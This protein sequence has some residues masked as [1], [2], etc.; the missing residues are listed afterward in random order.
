MN[1]KLKSL[2]AGMGPSPKFD[3]N[4]FGLK[5]TAAGPDM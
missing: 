1:A 4:Y 2:A 5:N 3:N